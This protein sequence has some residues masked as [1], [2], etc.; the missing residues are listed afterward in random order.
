MATNFRTSNAFGGYHSAFG[1]FKI[2]LPPKK[3]GG[4]SSFAV[5]SG[6]YDPSLDY[7]QQAASRGVQDLSADTT[8]GN[9]RLQDDYNLGLGQNTEDTQYGQGQ[10]DTSHTRT[11]ADIAQARGR[12]NED[13][14]LATAALTRRYGIL[15]GQQGEAANAAGVGEGGAL[16]QAQQKRTANQ[17]IDQ[18]PIDLGH[19]RT[20]ADL[21]TQEGRTNE[22]YATQTARESQL[23]GRA[24]GGLGLT[25][26]RG[27]QDANRTLARARRENTFYGQGIQQQK[28]FQATQAGWHPPAPPKKKKG[29]R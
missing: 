22:D 4:I 29:K 18:A 3:K 21:A 26:E 14:G 15:G 19:N 12:A 16:I 11:L 28:I 13:Y 2:K 8:L 25:Y 27:T 1:N 5:P 7:Q 6:L 9:A 20:L 23:S 10:L 24:A 17:A